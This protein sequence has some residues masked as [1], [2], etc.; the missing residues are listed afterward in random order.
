MGRTYRDSDGGAAA[1]IGGEV[2]AIVTGRPTI[3]WR[4]PT[5]DRAL[6]LRRSRGSRRIPGRHR[7]VPGLP[8]R[9]RGVGAGTGWRAMGP[10]SKRLDPRIA[11]P[12]VHRRP[13]CRHRR[14]LAGVL[15]ARLVTHPGRIRLVD[16]I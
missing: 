7:I 3:G 16:A 12:G 15:L 13:A 14:R 4:Q 2:L 1:G 6:E 11:L 9:A 5:N 10:G 8:P